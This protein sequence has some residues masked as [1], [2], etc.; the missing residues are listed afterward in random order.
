MEGLIQRDGLARFRMGLRSWIPRPNSGSFVKDLLFV[1]LLVF[2]Q[3]T[4]LPAFFGTMSFIDLITPW[5]VVTCV[6]Q[7]PL[8]ATLICLLAA[9]TLETRLAV[10]AGLYLCN[11]WIL[12]NVIFQFRGALSW[13]YKTPWFVSYLVA[14]LWVILFESFVI[15]FLHQNWLPQP[16][17]IFQQL[18]RVVIGVVFGMIL[19]REW[20]RIDAEEPVPQ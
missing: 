2:A 18:L 17:Y 13:R 4:L 7:H 1:L 14:G 12:A 15:A 19:S 9:S 11:Y 8:Q 6:R 3:T 16:A 10:P 20:M 5:L